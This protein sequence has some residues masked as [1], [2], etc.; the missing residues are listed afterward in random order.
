M[1]K[2]LGRA[3]AA[4]VLCGAGSTGYANAQSGVAFSVPSP[5][6]SAQVLTEAGIGTDPS[7]TDALIGQGF[8]TVRASLRGKCLET[9]PLTTLLGDSANA[10]GQKVSY[11]LQSATSLSELRSKLEVH[12][13]ASF[14][15]GIY[16]GSGSYNLFQETNIHS[17][18]SFL[19]V[20]V[21]VLNLTET[22]TERLLSGPAKERQGNPGRFRDFCGNEALIARQ[23]GGDF[24]ALVRFN[25]RSV[26]D[27][28][29]VDGAIGG[30][31]GNFVSGSANFAQS[32]T[33]LSRFSDLT[34]DILKAGNSSAIPT[35]EGLRDYA[36]R[37]PTTV[38]R[39]GGQPWV[40][41]VITADY[42]TVDNYDGTGD[43]DLPTYNAFME[44]LAE[45][46]DWALVQRNDIR[47]A[48]AD[49]ATSPG[50]DV[51][52]LNA[53]A[54]LLDKFLKDLSL[55]ARK[56]AG[57]SS[58]DKI[59]QD[60][61]GGPSRP[62]L[63]GPG[64][65]L[66]PFLKA[67]SQ[68]ERQFAQRGKPENAIAPIRLLA[69]ADGSKEAPRE[70][71]RAAILLAQAYLWQMGR[72]E[73]PFQGPGQ[74]TPD[75][76]LLTNFRNAL[77]RAKT[78][79]SEM[80][81]SSQ[82]CELHYL[83]ALSGFISIP[84]NSTNPQPAA[85]VRSTLTAAKLMATWDNKSCSSYDSN[86]IAR[87][88]GAVNDML[89]NFHRGPGG[90]ISRVL[91]HSAE[92]EQSYREAVVATPRNPMNYLWYIYFHQGAPSPHVPLNSNE[93]NACD[94]LRSFILTPNTPAEAG[95]EPALGEFR[96]R[97]RETYL[98]RSLCVR[99]SGELP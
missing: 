66:S 49:A 31:V 22:I 96:S 71:Y 80:N 33:A 90:D 1:D 3:M 73:T 85:G 64:A 12:A 32:I 43:F 21:K 83:T 25:S 15:I 6:E 20:R 50:L 58:A 55:S 89:V 18:S 63:G 5:R 88:L 86:G 84:F 26:E 44:Q 16:S 54:L 41:N 46:R 23:S 34:I 27:K 94:H 59:R 76:A 92:A 7:N 30:A 79:A 4:L 48:L 42:G 87:H 93:K 2:L 77:A 9:K 69:S 74:L 67:L 61:S 97:A 47:R 19:I 56:C 35:L 78:A 11:Y 45:D 14:G 36:L 17:L 13:S 82:A 60:C 40:Y 95:L 52:R 37:F 51:D 8:D 29:A 68:A 98:R 39:T 81:N 65:G 28:S 57:S 53:D 10:N 70:R 75:A 24:L 72:F 99:L 38:T 91:S 62:S